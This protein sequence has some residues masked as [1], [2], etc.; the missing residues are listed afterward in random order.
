MICFLQILTVS[1]QNLTPKTPIVLIPGFVD[2]QIEAT[3]DH[4]KY[5]IPSRPRHCSS[6]GSHAWKFFKVFDWLPPKLSCTVNLLELHYDNNTGEIVDTKNVNV[7]VIDFGGIDGINKLVLLP[8]GFQIIDIYGE[9]IRQL[10]QLHGYVVRKDLF[11]APY[12]WRLGAAQRD[13]YWND[14]QNLI[15]NAYE[16]N[17]GEKVV[18]IAHSQGVNLFT[19]FLSNHMTAAWRKKYIKRVAFLAP[20]YAG[21]G[22]ALMYIWQ[23]GIPILQSYHSEK[24][25]FAMRSLPG[26]MTLFPNQVIFG[27]KPIF[28]DPQGKPITA[29]TLPDY[30]IKNGIFVGQ[31]RKIFEASLKYLKQVPT[32][33]DVET[34]IYYN[35]N[36]PT[37]NGMNF[38]VPNYLPKE[39]IYAPGDGKVPAAGPQYVCKKWANNTLV[40]CVDSNDATDHGDFLIKPEI[41]KNVINWALHDDTYDFSF[42]DL[43]NVYKI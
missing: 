25:A 30:F 8:G 21:F 7:S 18:V 23:G 12:D 42:A 37:L 5:P 9:Y 27:D 20:A 14:M 24:L 3:F 15:E 2:S 33:I 34:L 35:S 17:N 11:G 6:S 1:L 29:K 26:F 4:N 22:Q 31:N 38:S 36:V 43:K 16:I 10:T 19:E 41:A 13:S 40:N 32:F 39:I 28:Y